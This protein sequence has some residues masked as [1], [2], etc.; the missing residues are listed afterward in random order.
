[1]LPAGLLSPRAPIPAEGE[2]RFRVR[3]C[4]CDPMGVAHHS[5]CIPWFEV[6]RTELLRAAGMT[7]AQM[8][9]SGIFLVVTRLEVKYRAPARYDDLMVLTTRVSG[10]GRARIDHEY[11]LWCDREDGRGRSE[12]LVT[13]SSTLACV[14]ETG[15]IRELPE[16]MRPGGPPS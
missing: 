15:A 5:A 6:G 2:C 11:E 3:Y 14:D 10:T 12:L 4:E 1:M 16:W 13:A 7:Y 8:E 9:A